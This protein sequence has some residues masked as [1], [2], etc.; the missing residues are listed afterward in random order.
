MGPRDAERRGVRRRAG[1]GH[2]GPKTELLE[3]LVDDEAEE[4]NCKLVE[5]V[6]AGNVRCLYCVDR[7]LSQPPVDSSPWP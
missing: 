6:L 3:E 4:L 7:L 2:P 1:V 5:L